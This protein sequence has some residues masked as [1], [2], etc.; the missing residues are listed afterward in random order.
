[1][2]LRFDLPGPDPDR[3]LNRDDK[4]LPVSDFSGTG[5]FGNRFDQG[6]E[7]LVT[8]NDLKSYFGKKINHHETAAVFKSDTL[9]FAPA[10]DLS[11]SHPVESF[12]FKRF[13]Y[14]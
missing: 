8:N 14:K 9:L 2:T 1:Q 3:L 5:R 6:I 11:N 13:F 4:D 10:F 7:I 12:V